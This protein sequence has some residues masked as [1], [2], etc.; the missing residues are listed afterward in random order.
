M[1]LVALALGWGV[2]L[3]SISQNGGEILSTED[4]RFVLYGEIV[5]TGLIIAFAMVVA[6][7][8]VNRMSSKRTSDRS[9]KF[10]TTSDAK[11]SSA[12]TESDLTLDRSAR[13][14]KSDETNQI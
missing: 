12:L 9:Q 5:L 8:E 11:P 10:A 3:I 7:L 14:S 4:N 2:Y 6:I 1:L 13:T